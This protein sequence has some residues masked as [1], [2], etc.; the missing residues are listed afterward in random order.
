MMPSA[1]LKKCPE[2][3]AVFVEIAARPRCEMA[4]EIL[5][6]GLKSGGS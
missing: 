5:D 1:I 6:E 4:L 3:P 2:L